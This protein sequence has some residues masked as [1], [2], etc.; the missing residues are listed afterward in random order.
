MRNWL[1]SCTYEGHLNTS[2]G[3]YVHLHICSPTFHYII[4]DI[5]CVHAGKPPT[6]PSM[7]RP[8]ICTCMQRSRAHRNSMQVDVHPVRGLLWVYCRCT[9]MIVTVCIFERKRFHA[10]SSCGNAGVASCTDL[11]IG[12]TFAHAC[13]GHLHIHILCRSMYTLWVGYCGFTPGVHE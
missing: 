5:F 13:K 4:N 12:H 2:M 11:R 6:S 9:R 1:F 7:T 10:V 3:Q 8:H